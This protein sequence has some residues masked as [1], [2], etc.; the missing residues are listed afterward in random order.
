M[1]FFFAR[2]NGTSGIHALPRPPCACWHAVGG[3]KERWNRTEELVACPVWKELAY[4]SDK[5]L[6][7]AV[8]AAMGVASAAGIVPQRDQTERRWGERGGERERSM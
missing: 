6:T 5:S 2:T 8:A 7:M 1:F 4:M 3:V